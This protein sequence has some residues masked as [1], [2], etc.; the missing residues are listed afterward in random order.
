[1]WI[2]NSQNIFLTDAFNVFEKKVILYYIAVLKIKKSKLTAVF[3]NR[4]WNRKY[5]F[6]ISS[7]FVSESICRS[8]KQSC[9]WGCCRVNTWPDENAPCCSKT[10]HQHHS[11]TWTERSHP[12]GAHTHRSSTEWKE[13]GFYFFTWIRLLTFYNDLEQFNSQVPEKFQK[14]LRGNF[15]FFQA[16]FS[17]WLETSSRYGQLDSC[18]LLL[19]AAVFIRP[20]NIVL[21][22]KSKISGCHMEQNVVLT[23]NSWIILKQEK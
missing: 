14:D 19:R 18:V 2:Q 17:A 21:V 22:F 11:D 16:T 1:M 13:S 7:G 15:L 6:F 23:F 8:A 4:F 9:W 10:I 20:V 12:A 5:F 3:W